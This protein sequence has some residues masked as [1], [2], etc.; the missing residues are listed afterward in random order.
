MTLPPLFAFL[1]LSDNGVVIT[2]L[3]VPNG[4]SVATRAGVEE[5]RWHL[6]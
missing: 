3:L 2:C 6:L 5:G 4:Q 1:M